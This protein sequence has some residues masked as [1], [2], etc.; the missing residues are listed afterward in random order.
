MVGETGGRG[1]QQQV[2][3]VETDEE[4]KG[5]AVRSVKLLFACLCGFWPIVR[6]A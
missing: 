1:A 4:E 3:G 6:S 2:Q 5:P